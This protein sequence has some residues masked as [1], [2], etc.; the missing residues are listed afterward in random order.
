MNFHNIYDFASAIF[1]VQRAT[2]PQTQVTVAEVCSHRLYRHSPRG[3][4]LA[5]LNAAGQ[6]A[7]G[8]DPVWSLKI[9][10]IVEGTDIEASSEPLHWPL[11]AEQFWAACERVNASLDDAEAEW[12]AQ[13]DD[14][15]ATQSRSG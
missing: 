9:T 10:G 4:G 14:T 12:D 2:P 1:D 6:R 5:P 15:H 3:L 13:G 11:S 7:S 8:D